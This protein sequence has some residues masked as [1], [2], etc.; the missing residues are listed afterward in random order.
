MPDFP[1][2]DAGLPP[3]PGLMASPGKSD[4][5]TSHTQQSLSMA[6]HINLTHISQ[7]S[8]LW[9]LYGKEKSIHSNSHSHRPGLLASIFSHHPFLPA[10]P[11]L[12]CSRMLFSISSEPQKHLDL[13]EQK[14]CV[15]FQAE[16]FSS[17]HLPCPP[18]HAS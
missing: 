6:A 4:G 2:D 7:R 9:H 13:P 3:Y 17:F 16:G 1:R 12:P 11:W 10:P 14:I 18:P 15:V 8:R 5:W